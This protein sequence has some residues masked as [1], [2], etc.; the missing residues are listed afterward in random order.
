M[1]ASD[2]AASETVAGRIAEFL[3]VRG[4]DRIFGLCGGHVMPIWDQAAR[5]GIRIV[6]VRDE[7]AAAH[8]AH[9]HA[10]LTGGIGV[11]LA[12]AGPG[13]T[14]AMTGVVNAHVARAPIVVIS[15]VPP[16]PQERMGAL[17]DL[18][19]TDLLRSVTRY[20]R[21]VLETAHVLP[22]L[23]EAFARAIGD[24]C[25][26]GPIYLDFPTDL[27]REHLPGHLVFEEHRKAKPKPER[28]PD[29]DAVGRAVEMLWNAKRPLVVSGRGAR[30]AGP[31]L[32][33]LLDALDAVYL[34]TSES[35]SL[36]PDAH[37]AVVSSLRGQVMAEADVV[38]TVGRRLDFQLAYGSPAIFKKAAFRTA[39]RIRIRA[40]RQPARAC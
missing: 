22:A 28:L 14:N 26:P 33:A 23:D 10:E 2:V 32:L 25:V 29:A 1:G 21:T 40:S 9:A 35:R 19:H 27:L 34:D 11:V 24:G 3:A 15:G 4:I 36:V 20:A 31:E 30:E 7:R 37:P 18:V 6:D 12:T 17:Q 5:G 16:R 39:G 13:V 8:M 38:L